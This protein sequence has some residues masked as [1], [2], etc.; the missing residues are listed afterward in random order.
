MVERQPERRKGERRKLHKGV[1]IQQ[2]K[3]VRRVQPERRGAVE[4]SQRAKCGCIAFTE[5]RA[6]EYVD[7]IFT[8]NCPTHSD[9]AIAAVYQRGLA[10]GRQE[11]EA[12][13][14]ERDSFRELH[15]DFARALE[16]Q[17][18]KADEA[19]RKW[20]AEAK[21]AAAKVA[22]SV[23]ADHAENWI[24]R[25]SARSIAEAI[26]ALEPKESA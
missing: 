4:P 17:E 5:E 2:R 10:D 23:D 18:R 13:R 11:L 12:V 1:L 25:V 26:R 15:A 8:D 14:R 24:A 20:Y 19:E 9:A 22:D 7:V 6:E 3:K 16:A 21:E